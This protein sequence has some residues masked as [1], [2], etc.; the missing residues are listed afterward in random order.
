MKSLT[1]LSLLLVTLA[2]VTSCGGAFSQTPASLPMP[3]LVSHEGNSTVALVTLDTDNTDDTVSDVRPTCSAVWVDDK[4]ILTALHCVRGEQKHLQAQQDAKEEAEKSA[5]SECNPLA[6]ILGFCSTD[7][8]VEHKVIGMQDMP[9]HY[10]TWKEV[11]DVAKEPTGQHLAHV[12][13]MD[14]AHDLALLT[15][16]G[17]AIPAHEVAKVAAQVPGMGERVHVCG[18]VK[19]LYWT[20]L[21]GTMAGYRGDLPNFRDDRKDEVQRQGPIMQLQVPVSFGNSGG[22]AFNDQGE[23]I[24]IA[25]FLLNLPAEGFF[26]PVESIHAFLVNHD[27]LPGHKTVK[28][29][30]P[31][32]EVT[33]PV[34]VVPPVMVVVPPVVAAATVVKPHS[35][36]GGLGNVP[37]P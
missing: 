19:G 37:A 29:E 3:Q 20:F 15:A 10:I 25:D 4:H 11:D 33:P 28:K 27:V 22:G 30:N 16:A 26:V 18:H 2:C 1:A 5:Q 23:L 6:A 17:H 14:E 9:M 31:T 35:V 13:A 24:G 7:Q 32:P 8:Q 36:N 12:A 34:A 21:E